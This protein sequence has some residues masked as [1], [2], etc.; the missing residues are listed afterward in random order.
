MGQ[1]ASGSFYCLFTC[2]WWATSILCHC[3]LPGPAPE[4]LH[5]H[6]GIT[7]QP[8]QRHI[9]RGSRRKKVHLVQLSTTTTLHQPGCRP[10]C[11]S[12]PSP[13][14]TTS[15]DNTWLSI[16]S[17]TSKGYLIQD[18]ITDRKL[19]L[20]T[21]QRFLPAEWIHSQWVCYMLTVLG[22]F[23]IY[24]GNINL[25]LTK[26]FT[27]C[28]ES[29]GCQQHT[30]LQRTHSGFDLLWCHP[31]WTRRLS[32]PDHNLN[33]LDP[34]HQSCPPI[35]SMAPRS[36]LYSFQSPSVNIQGHPQPAPH[37]CPTSSIFPLPQILFLFTPVC[38]P[39]PVSPP[40]LEFINTPT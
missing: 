9:Y 2:Q 28:L 27:S 40:S 11:V 4:A 3:L 17:L 34:P 24:R 26:D 22:D 32:C 15:C 18:L 16:C 37:I 38:P 10:Q 39:Q 31:S 7:F 5:L 23:I 14:T 1:Y 6:Q 21:A 19:D 29:F 33:P 12:P 13:S 36:V 35:A 20:A 8:R 25:P 30:T